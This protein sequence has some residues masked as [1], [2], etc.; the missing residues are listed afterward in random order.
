MR[1]SPPLENSP[2]F[3]AP[4]LGIGPGKAQ[5]RSWTTRATASGSSGGDF[6]PVAPVRLESAVG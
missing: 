1:I 6:V 5:T 3:S 4:R 2:C